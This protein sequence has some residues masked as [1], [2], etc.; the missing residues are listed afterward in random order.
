VDFGHVQI[1]KVI[2][3]DHCA[4][5]EHYIRGWT[6]KIGCPETCLLDS[7]L[8]LNKLIDNSPPLG[9]GAGQGAPQGIQ[10]AHFDLLSCLVGNVIIGEMA[11]KF[12][13]FHGNLF[14]DLILDFG[15]I[16]LN[17]KLLLKRVEP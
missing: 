8:A 2:T 5:P 1:I 15:L 16:L 6:N 3:M 9:G 17:N 14:H 12:S 11:D 7:F 10:Q 13:Q 4:I